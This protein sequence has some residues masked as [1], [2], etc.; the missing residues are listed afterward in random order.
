MKK[1]GGKSG[2][3]GSAL[4]EA[5]VKYLSDRVAFIDKSSRLNRKATDAFD[6]QTT[7]QTTATSFG[8]TARKFEAS[9]RNATKKMSDSASRMYEGI[10]VLLLLFILHQAI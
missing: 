10:I 4:S 1:T 5:E 3:G 7:A 8:Q 2:Q 6:S 9:V